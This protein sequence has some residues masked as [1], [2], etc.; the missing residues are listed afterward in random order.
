MQYYDPLCSIILLV[1]A[2]SQTCIDSNLISQSQRNLYGLF[3]VI[4]NIITTSF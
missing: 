3:D 1:Y 2:V 4:K